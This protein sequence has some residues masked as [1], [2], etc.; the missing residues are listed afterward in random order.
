MPA[1]VRT[2]FGGW[3][4]H[5]PRDF[6]YYAVP[7]EVPGDL[8]TILGCRRVER[9]VATDQ[10]GAPVAMVRSNIGRAVQQLPG[11]GGGIYAA[12]LYSLIKETVNRAPR[13]CSEKAANA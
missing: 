5:S 6:D 1:E 9:P 7:A 12:A 2:V 4:L 10:R 11:G 8:K 13:H 3:T